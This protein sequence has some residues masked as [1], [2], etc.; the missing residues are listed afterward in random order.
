MDH[1]ARWILSRPRKPS[2]LPLDLFLGIGLVSAVMVN[3][4]ASRDRGTLLIGVASRLRS[5]P[6][7]MLLILAFAVTVGS[8]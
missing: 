5:D 1:L 7:P 8:T 2:D 3:D 4:A 6:K